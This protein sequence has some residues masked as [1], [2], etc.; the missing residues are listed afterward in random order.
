[1]TVYSNKVATVPRG[2]GLRHA[3]M[4]VPTKNQIDRSSASEGRALQ[5]SIQLNPRQE[6]NFRW[7]T[8]W[9]L[10]SC[11][12][13]RH[14]SFWRREFGLEFE[15]DAETPERDA[16]GGAD[17]DE[18][19]LRTPQDTL[20][21]TLGHPSIVDPSTTTA[22][23]E[24]L[25]PF[26]ALTQDVETI[27]NFLHHLRHLDESN[28]GSPEPPLEKAASDLI[29]RLNDTIRSREEASATTTGTGTRI[30]SHINRGW[31]GT[32]FSAAW[33][34]SSLWMVCWSL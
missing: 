6:V 10:L 11:P 7:R 19:E 18:V 21:D 27:D 17:E 12:S 26:L 28:V 16:T 3:S 14:P 15:D 29:R 1:M 22:P 8:S 23:V 31:R 13:Q 34:S 2:V 20:Q 5:C 24:P 32:R 33:K 4:V 9:L 30:S 25:D